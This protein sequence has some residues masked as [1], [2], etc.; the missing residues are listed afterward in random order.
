MRIV[1]GLLILTAIIAACAGSER[2][3][4]SKDVLFFK[5]QQVA[6]SPLKIELSGLSGHSAMSVRKITEVVNGESLQIVVYLTLATSGSSGNFD[7]TVTVP[8]S[9][10]SISFG[11]EKTVIWTRNAGV[12]WH[13]KHN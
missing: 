7:Y 11:N 8:P 2:I 13:E 1:F 4:E 5:V 9:A 3:L 12:V 6:S 10:N